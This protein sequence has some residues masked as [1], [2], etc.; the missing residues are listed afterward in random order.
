MTRTQARI[1]RETRSFPSL[2]FAMEQFEKLLIQLG[3]KAKVRFMCVPAHV[4]FNAYVWHMQENLMEGFKRSLAR[5]F[6]IDLEAMEDEGEGGGGGGGGESSDDVDDGDTE[7][8]P[9]PA[10]RQRTS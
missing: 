9:P 1:R 7:D 4:S 3:K 8:Q 5:D 10:K 6:R 2:I